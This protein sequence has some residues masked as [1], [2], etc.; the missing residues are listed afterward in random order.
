MK[1]ANP[2]TTT[3]HG[4]YTDPA[5]KGTSPSLWTQIVQA[6]PGLL[7]ALA[8]SAAAIRLADVKYVKE[9]LHLGAL[10]L[11]ILLGMLWKNVLPP[12][13]WALP[14]ISVA[15]RPVLRWGVAF[16]GF[17]LSL[18]KLVSVGGPALAVVVIA[19]TAA[20]AFG[21]WF[22]KAMGL[23]E[24]LAALLAVGGGVC[25]A[26]A[27]IATETVVKGERKD[28]AASIGVITLFG[29]IGI[30]LYPFL[31]HLLNLPQFL[32][33]VWTGASL[34]E[35]AQVVAAAQALHAEDVATVVKLARIAMLAPIV[36]YFAW[37]MRKS[38]HE[39]EAKVAIVPWFLVLFLVFA[40]ANSFLPIPKATVDWINNTGNLWLLC[41]GMAGVGLQTGFKDLKQAGLTAVLVGL[42]QW[43]FLAVL[44][45]ALAAVF[46]R[47][48]QPVS[49]SN[50]TTP[51]GN[52]IIP[53][54]Q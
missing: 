2:P 31:G 38:G 43:I 49:D 45:F 37:W 40:L 41:I 48:P 7:L 21:F 10:L 19:T 53:R 32:Y 24:R 30:L 26:S 42:V 5:P 16:L 20:V 13:Q 22:A 1:S 44:S 29:T 47:T 46:C 33:G 23:N 34:H 4:N 17:K 8:V 27:I 36:F 9:T 12:P 14:G 50:S 6:L 51:K 25:G 39:A 18:V 35:T 54:P 52:V 28:V 3:L 15:Q 11:V